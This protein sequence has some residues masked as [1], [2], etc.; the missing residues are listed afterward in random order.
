M[1]WNHLAIPHVS[2]MGKK[3]NLLNCTFMLMY[4]WFVNTM[5]LYSTKNLYN[6]FL[7]DLLRELLMACVLILGKSEISQYGVFPCQALAMTNSSKVNLAAQR[8]GRSVRVAGGRA[9]ESLFAPLLPSFLPS[10][11]I[12][13][14][15]LRK[16][17]QL[18]LT[19]SHEA[20]NEMRLLV[21]VPAG[22]HVV[23]RVDHEYGS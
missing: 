10:P 8:E 17:V 3:N 7:D 15:S 2:S 19:S 21:V 5:S 16:S 18:F 11:F 12:V 4:R 1:E 6:L 14:L 13:S 22:Q 9:G 20:G 23:G